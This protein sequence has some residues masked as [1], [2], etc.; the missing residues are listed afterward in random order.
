M[1]KID[2]QPWQDAAIRDGRTKWPLTSL[3]DIG[4]ICGVSAYAV[5]RRAHV[6]GVATATPPA[7]PRVEVR[8]EPLPPGDPVSWDAITRGTSLAGE[9]YR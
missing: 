5:L 2:W 4:E 6:I 9:A 7:P 8:V 1:R 3:V